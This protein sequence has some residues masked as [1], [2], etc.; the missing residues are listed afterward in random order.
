[1]DYVRKI[2]KGLEQPG[3]IVNIGRTFSHNKQLPIMD[4]NK[5]MR[6]IDTGYTFGIE[7]VKN[8]LMLKNVKQEFWSTGNEYV[9]P[10]MLEM[11]EYNE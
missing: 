6:P 7:T 10:A 2:F 1:M 9:S 11:S 8:D 4:K 3:Y 5:I